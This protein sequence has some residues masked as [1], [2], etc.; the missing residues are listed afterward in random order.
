[1]NLRTNW[2]QSPFVRVSPSDPGPPLPGPARA[3]V[4]I[5]FRSGL[6]FRLR[7]ALW[8][9]KCASS[10]N[11]LS[12]GSHLPT[13]RIQWQEAARESGR[14]PLSFGSHLPTTTRAANGWRRGRMSQSPF[15]RVSPSDTASRPCT[16][17]SRA[18]S[19]SP[20]V[21]VSPSDLVPL[22]QH[23]ECR[24]ELS[25]SPFVRVSPSDLVR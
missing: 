23:P 14:N 20:F 8:R 5:P 4:A 9:R 22:R 25:Q 12:F 24:V 15:V 3:G 13:N 10:R 17:M 2:S 7:R 19:Q 6:T 18:T 16:A 11:P 21:R 1:M